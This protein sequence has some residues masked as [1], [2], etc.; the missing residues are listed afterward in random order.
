MAPK[1]KTNPF[2]KFYFI[3][4]GQKDQ[5]THKKKE[6]STQSGIRPTV[7]WSLPRGNSWDLD[8]QELGS[9][10]LPHRDEEWGGMGKAGKAIQCTC[11]KHKRAVKEPQR[12]EGRGWEQEGWQTEGKVETN[13]EG[14]QAYWRI[15]LPATEHCSEERCLGVQKGC[16]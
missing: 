14:S 1:Y 9:T 3:F 13:P 2:F 15:H 8:Y 7:R 11:L 12:W 10:F 6:G 5:H 16:P 4:L